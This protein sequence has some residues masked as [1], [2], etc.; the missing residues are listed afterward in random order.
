M[1]TRWGDPPLERQ[2]PTRL[3]QL[4]AHLVVALVALVGI[5]GATRVMEAGLA[6]PDWPLCYGSLLPGGRMNMQVFLEWFHRLDA[7]VVG[8]ALLVL[9]GVSVWQRRK[10]PRW[11]P[12]LSA[13]ALALVMVQGGLGALT[14]LALLPSA[15]VTAHLA[16]ALLLVG[17]LSAAS[18][19]LLHADL[20]QH[21]GK[22][23]W[24][25]LTASAASLIAVLAQCLLG[26]AM[27]TQ[28]AAERC[29]T[30]GIACQWLGAHRHTATIVAI[31]VAIQAALSLT[32][33]LRPVVRGLS[34][35][36]AALVLVQLVLGISS[37]HLQLQAPLITVAHQ[38]TAALLVAVLTAGLSREVAHG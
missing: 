5:G 22:T 3:A 12:W 31:A 4:C 24:M 19:Q 17:V 36:A 10:L 21:N 2:L 7:F 28:W 35:T 13:L 18:Q 20:P 32:A 25:W 6:C 37:L 26:G 15:V 38:V 11:L 8:V 1:E 14:V 30:S 34:L 29:L 33:G 16:T 9:C 27:A 23:P